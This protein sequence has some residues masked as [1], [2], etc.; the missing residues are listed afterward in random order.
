[1]LD[2]LA[3]IN[4]IKLDLGALREPSITAEGQWMQRGPRCFSEGDVVIGIEGNRN[5]FSHSVSSQNLKQART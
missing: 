4:S 2:D 5:S 1:M 3:G